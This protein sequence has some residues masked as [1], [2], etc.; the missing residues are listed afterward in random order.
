MSGGGAVSS[1][2]VE[3]SS[4][5][6]GVFV[7]R[8]ANP[9]VNALAPELLDGLDEALDLAEKDGARVVVIAS[10]VPR[11]FAAG[12]DIKTMVDVDR[13]GFV[14]YGLRLRSTV[15]R[16]AGLDRP[17]I[18]AVEGSALGGGMELALACCLRVASRTS[19]VGLP[20]AKIGLIPSAGATQRLPRYVGRGR[21]LE[22]MLTARP[23]GAE[24]ALAI[25][26]VD[27]V[28]E[29]G[30]AAATAV[31]L[32]GAMAALSI[33]ALMDVIALVDSASEV[34]LA[35]GLAGEVTRVEAL[36]DGPDAREGMRAFL[37]KRS[38]DF[39]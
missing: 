12:A 20:E 31:E 11:F 10:A 32:A 30:E 39:R 6:D 37:E 13:D 17:T 36:F 15:E 24:E 9:P 4:S 1:S 35:E 5:D 38:P 27:R 7:V 26:L 19:R 33:P 8:M 14:A 3:V 34:P 16:I 2:A 28:C 23:V 18:A 29:P 25:G 22:L 21:A